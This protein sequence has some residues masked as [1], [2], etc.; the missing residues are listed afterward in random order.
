[1][2]NIAEIMPEL[3]QDRGIQ[4]FSFFECRTLLRADF[5]TQHSKTWITWQYA[6]QSKCY[7]CYSK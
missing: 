4:T 6:R 5:F 3:N 1:M 2:Q 7:E